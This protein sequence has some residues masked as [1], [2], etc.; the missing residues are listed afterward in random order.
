MVQIIGTKFANPALS[1]Q[2]KTFPGK[3]YYPRKKYKQIFFFS[4]TFFTVRLSDGDSIVNTYK[5]RVYSRPLLRSTIERCPL[6][7]KLC[8]ALF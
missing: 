8:K 1:P 2:A 6:L 4:K 5:G 7:R 3:Q